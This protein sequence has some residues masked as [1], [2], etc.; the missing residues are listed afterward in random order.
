M[1]NR[2]LSML[3]LAQ[4]ARKLVSGEFTVDKAIKEKTARLVVIAEDA[5]ANTRKGFTDSCKYY[6]VPCM[7]Y[8]SKEELGHCIGKEQRAVIAILD[9]GMADSVGRLLEQANVVRADI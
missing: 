6:H 1:N 7:V 2:V 8:G 9:D 4:R 3:G 5:S